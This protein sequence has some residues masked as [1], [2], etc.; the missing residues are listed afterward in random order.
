MRLDNMARTYYSQQSHENIQEKRLLE[1][2]SALDNQHAIFIT[3]RGSSPE[4]F[5]VFRPDGI[6]YIRQ[7]RA[8]SAVK[9]G[10]RFGPWLLADASNI[11][12]PYSG[13]AQAATALS[14]SLKESAAQI[15]DDPE[16]N[17]SRLNEFIT[18]L[19]VFPILIFF[20]PKSETVGIEKPS[21]GAFYPTIGGVER[22]FTHPMK[23]QHN[24]PAVSLKLSNMEIERIARRLGYVQR[25]ADAQTATASQ[26]RRVPDPYEF[27]KEAGGANFFGRTTEL[28]ELQD[29]I[30]SGK[31]VAVFG[32]QRVGKTSLI[33]EAFARA[34]PTAEQ[35]PLFV[36][37][38]LHR[39]SVQP[40]APS[41]FLLDFIEAVVFS[42]TNAVQ[43]AAVPLGTLQKETAQ[44]L[45]SNKR[46]QQLAIALHKFLEGLRSHVGKRICIFVDELQVLGE[47]S[48]SS[49]STRLYQSFIRALGDTAKEA[50][51]QFFF[52]GRLSVLKFNEVFDWQLLKLCKKLEIGF[53]D[54]VSAKEL[55]TKP[56]KSFL[57]WDATAVEELIRLTGG[58]PYFLQYICSALVSFANN[59][60]ANRILRE[61]VIAVATEI[62]RSKVEQNTIRLLYSDFESSGTLVHDLLERIATSS[63]TQVREEDAIPPALRGK[64]QE[65]LAIL[66]LQELCRADLLNL[67]SNSGHR[68]YSLKVGLIKKY[69][70]SAG[71]LPVGPE[72]L[73]SA[74]NVIDRIEHL[75]CAMVIES[76]KAKYGANESGWWKQG[77]P[78]KI[79]LRIV[80]L[81]EDDPERLDYEAYFFTIE[82]KEIIEAQWELF[83]PIFCVDAQKRASDNL[84]W[85]RKINDIR[86]SAMHST[87]A[88][89][90][91]GV[92]TDEMDYLRERL[93]WL[94]AQHAK[95]QSATTG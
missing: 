92:K 84:D 47:A 75:L 93:N 26:L 48:K 53:L 95:W 21:W 78:T 17:T 10:P 35:R 8:T 32:L 18:D 79:R 27:A 69:F 62:V 63:N 37:V 74:N 76:L 50:P 77:V 12:N 71:V 91:G 81:R 34:Y 41:E 57:D 90:R 28:T 15:I 89:A 6:H 86:K 3:P 46:P 73:G 70:E 42:A 68:A 44:Y 85:I 80:A 16:K 40:D 36:E 39:L 56:S 7:V 88:K 61:D 29:F 87:R 9:S 30:R 49:D 82:Y 67:A 20:A 11:P 33:K 51:I 38:N 45:T 72:A 65:K 64:D 60:N 19:K 5:V 58:H 13:I 59:K 43:T 2:L 66:L 4:D 22:Y 54:S 23:W 31:H 24:R 94:E 25:G 55:V 14:G 83:K 1:A 52:S